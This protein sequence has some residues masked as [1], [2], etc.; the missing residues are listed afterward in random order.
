MAPL[1]D[2]RGG[3]KLLPP[4]TMLE[5]DSVALELKKMGCTEIEAWEALHK[6]QRSDEI[7]TWFGGKALPSWM[8]G[9]TCPADRASQRISNP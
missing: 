7:E 1:S 5:K 3:F 2:H 6:G 4:G 8:E 9:E